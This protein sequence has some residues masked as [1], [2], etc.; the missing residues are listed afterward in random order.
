MHRTFAVGLALVLAVVPVVG[1]PPK[2]RADE[3]AKEPLVDQVRTAIDNGV[4]FLRKDER[5]RGNWEGDI[6]SAAKTRQGGTTALALL[7]LL[8]CGI[9][10]DDPQIQAGLQWLRTVDPEAV[11]VVGLQTMVFAEVGDPKDLPRIQRNVDWLIRA[12]VMRDGQLRGWGYTE[13]FGS[14]DFSNSQYALLG[15]HAGKQ[16]GATVDVSVWESIQNFYKTTQDADGGW[17]YSF[18]YNPGPTTLTM[19]IAGL[20]GLS[21]VGQELDAGRRTLN[22]DGSDPKCGKYEENDAIRRALEWLGAGGGN[23]TRFQFRE[24]GAT[25]YNI[26]GIERAGR[27]TG[28]RFL[29]GH[30]WYR[31]GCEFLVQRQHEGGS[32]FFAGERHDAYV[33]ISTTF[34]LLFLSKGRTPILISK[35]AHDPD[36]DWNNKHH[37]ARHLVEFASKELFRRQPLAWQVYDARKLPSLNRDQMREEVG[38]LLQSPILYMNGHQAPRLT[39]IQ[40]QLLRQYLDEGGFLLA[41]A[42]CGRKEFA[43]G[44]RALMKDAALF[45]DTELAP[46]RPDHPIWSAHFAVNPGFVRLEGIEQGCKTVVVFSPQPLAGYWEVNK[47]TPRAG[48]LQIPT[49]DRGTLA[50][51]LAGN[52]IAYATGLEM[53]KPRLTTVALPEDTEERRVARGFLK[54]AQLEHGGDWQP[55]PRAMSNLMRFMSSEHKLDV[56]LQKDDLPIN[57]PDIY[58][59]KFLYM[60]GRKAFDVPAEQLENLRANLKAG[61]LLLADAC[62]GK[63]EFDRAFRAFALKLFPDAKLEPIPPDDTLFGADINGTPITTVRLRKERPDGQGAEAEFRDTRPTHL[64]GIKLNGRW[65]VIYSKYDIGCALEK[66]ASS[67]CKGYDHDSALHIGAAAVLYGLKK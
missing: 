52:I 32:W 11:Y 4:R 28:Q 17:V 53:P 16:A 1:Q 37:D 2:P 20:C 60:H 19:T 3:P 63:P 36:E 14:T 8:N 45:P 51:R 55:A 49:T 25:Y 40:K 64:E 61:G 12:R 47:W 43:D 6:S 18:N 67:D 31:E 59:Y 62:C 56:S 54:V 7:A 50:F 38:S 9:K 35:L 5:G 58:L 13:T 15:L 44:F 42:C 46:L 22:P 24:P 33:T 30:D 29:A 34:A 26:Y 41:E 48:K 65:V 27:L 57:S 23:G 66:H 10:P 39:P 21:I